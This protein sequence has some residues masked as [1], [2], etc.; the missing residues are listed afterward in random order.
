MALNDATTASPLGTTIRYSRNHRSPADSMIRT[1]ATHR[2]Q[3]SRRTLAAALAT[4]LLTAVSVEGVAR[5]ALG[6]GDPPLS[7]ALPDIEYVFRPGTYRRFGNTVHVN[8]WHMRSAEIAAHKTDADEVRV[9]FMGDSVVNGGSLT[10]QADLATER[11]QHE[12]RSALAR[13]VVVGNISAGSWGPGN[14]L[15][16]TRRFGLFEAD[17]VV[18]VLNSLDASDNP[19]GEPIVGVD[20]SFPAERPWFAISEGF[21]RYLLPRVWT[22]RIRLPTL[23]DPAEAMA[24]GIRAL[25]DLVDVAESRGAAVII[26]HFPNRSELSGTMLPG[27]AAIAQLAAERSVP[28]IE[29]VPALSAA[30]TAGTDPYRANDTIHPNAMGQRILADK[31]LPVILE[32]IR[33]KTAGR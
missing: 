4:V 33:T 32:V 20:P 28:F 15:A 5:F 8:A 9:M 13:P 31:V 27:H 14:L 3:P 24:E 30:V 17:V 16:Y 7:V 2:S 22:R 1:L 21:T 18:L 6:L 10:D 12:L 23:P 11:V 25:G 26:L 19:T 29:L